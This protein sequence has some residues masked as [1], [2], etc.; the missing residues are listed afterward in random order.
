MGAT[1]RCNRFVDYWGWKDNF[2]NLFSCYHWVSVPKRH[3]QDLMALT[4]STGNSEWRLPCL[5]RWRS[6]P[7]GTSG[8][9]PACQRTG[10]RSGFDPW[11]GKIPWRRAWQPTPVFLPGES[12]DRGAWWAMVHGLTKSQ[13]WLSTHMKMRSVGISSP[14]QAVLLTELNLLPITVTRS[15]QFHFPMQYNFY[16]F[17][18]VERGDKNHKHSNFCLQQTPRLAPCILQWSLLDSVCFPLQI[19]MSSPLPLVSFPLVDSFNI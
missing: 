3:L 7:G 14:S 4:W 19:V 2:N 6:S 5:W 18:I 8:R 16:P 12:Q 10:L 17:L 1:F 15:L 11:V 13:T 9:E